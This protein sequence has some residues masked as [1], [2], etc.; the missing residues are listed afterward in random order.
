MTIPRDACSMHTLQ[1][2]TLS[3]DKIVKMLDSP[4]LEAIEGAYVRYS[5]MK[6][7]YAI[8]KIAGIEKG[9]RKRY[10][11]CYTK[12]STD[13]YLLLKDERKVGSDPKP[14]SVNK[15]SNQ[16]IAPRDF[17]RWQKQLAQAGI[18]PKENDIRIL[19]TKIQNDMHR[20]THDAGLVHE[21][22]K[23]RQAKRLR[24]GK[25]AVN[26]TRGKDGEKEEAQGCPPR[27]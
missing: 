14:C 9:R 13:I 27:A 10:D 7:R 15:I 19:N 18:L 20:I 3:R 4:A 1:S 5:I 26:A 8:L 21:Q 12:R 2:V 25:R 23:E 16:H 17:E 22:V 6:N 11:V 24:E